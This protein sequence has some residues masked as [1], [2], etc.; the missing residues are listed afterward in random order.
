MSQSKVS[1][2]QELD[3]EED[4][5]NDLFVDGFSTN[6]RNA[7]GQNTSGQNTSG[8][9]TSGQDRNGLNNNGLNNDI[10]SGSGQNRPPPKLSKFYKRWLGRVGIPETDFSSLDDKYIARFE[11]TAYVYMD[12]LRKQGYVV[13]DDMN[14]GMGI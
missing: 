13:E 10:S 11:A 2:K 12:E 3:D 6:A 1:V 9:N 5:D 8:Q 7:N 4:E 14:M